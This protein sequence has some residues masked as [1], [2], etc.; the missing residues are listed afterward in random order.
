M[1]Q[2]LNHGMSALNEM[3]KTFKIAKI[4]LAGDSVKGS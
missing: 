2:A 3:T 4:A 1:I